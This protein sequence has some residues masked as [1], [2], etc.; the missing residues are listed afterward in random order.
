MSDVKLGELGE[1]REGE[2]E[3]GPRGHR[4]HDGSTGPTGPSG[5]TGSP[6]IAAGS[7]TGTPATVTI[8]EQTGQFASATYNA[9]GNYLLTLN[10]IPGVVSGTQLIPLGTSTDDGRIVSI[11]TSFIAGHGVLI[12]HVVDDTGTPV[13]TTFFV[14]LA[15]VGA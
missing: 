14:H 10:A 11:N 13:D 4:G 12:V 3:R 5:P 1:L 6:T 9:V 7:F 15:L 8:N 2:G